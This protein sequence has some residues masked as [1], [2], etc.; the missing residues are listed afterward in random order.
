MSGGA[1]SGRK[2]SHYERELVTAFRKAGY[3]AL[4]LPSSGSATKRE[5]PDVLAGH[6]SGRMFAIEAKATNEKTAYVERE[7]VDALHAFASRWGAKP[8]ISGRFTS[9][10]ESTD[11]YLLEPENARMTPQGNYGIPAS[12][13]IER[14]YAVI[15]PGGVLEVFGGEVDG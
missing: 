12:D 13:A 10:S 7:E 5:L 4:R 11:H 15:E 14:A 8:L 1:S 6:R 9:R 2:G 3:G